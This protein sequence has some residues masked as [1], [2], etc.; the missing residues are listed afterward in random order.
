MSDLIYQT[1]ILGALFHDIG[2]FIQRGDFGNLDI[3]GRH[4]EVSATFIKSWGQF[5]AQWADL[6][7][8]ETLVTRHHES[9]VFPDSLRA[10]KAPEEIKTLC[11]LVSRADNYSSAERDT[12]TESRHF[13]TTPLTSVFS[14]IK[15]KPETQ[16]K[17]KHY[18]AGVFSPERAFPVEEDSLNPAATAALARDFGSAMEEISKTKWPSFRALYDCL[19]AILE[20]YCWCLP[21]ATQEE[22]PD[23]SLYDHL[24]TT[25]A[26]AAALY[27]Y[28]AAHNDFSIDSITDDTREKF[29]LLAGDLSGIQRYIFDIAAIGV[30]GVAKRLRAR[31]FY[32]SAVSAGLA[33]KIAYD[34]NLPSINIITMSGGNFYLLLPNTRPVHAYIERLR[35]QVN[36]DFLDRFGGELSLNLAQVPFAGKD[37]RRYNLVQRQAGEEL[38][39]AKL[40]PMADMLRHSDGSWLESAFVLE[41]TK[42]NSQ[43]Y[44]K[45]CGKLPV[46]KTMDDSA[47]CDL[48]YQD[49]A[50]GT[51]LP[52]AKMILFYHKNPQHPNSIEL[53]G[54]LW[55]LATDSASIAGNEI[56]VGYSLNIEEKKRDFT[57]IVR[58]VFGGNHVPHINGQPLDFDAIAGCSPGKK[59]LGVLKAD[60]DNLGALFSLGLGDRGTISRVATLS[61]MLDIFFSGWLNRLLIDKYPNVYLVYSGGDDLLAVGPWEQIT[62]L[63]NQVRADFVRFVGENPDITLSAGIAVVKPS[64]PIAHGAAA[65]DESLGKAKDKGPKVKGEAKDQCTLL[66]ETVKWEQLPTLIAQGRTLAG[67]LEQRLISARFVHHLLLYARMFDAYLLDRQVEGLRYIPLLSYDLN[68]NLKQ[69]EQTIEIRKWAQGLM[70]PNSPTIRHLALIARYA[71]LARRLNNA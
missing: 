6:A 25:A 13:K 30:G 21:A 3:G 71:L 20:D 9:T 43:G 37:F 46:T 58:K 57:T 14:R 28:H 26:I 2:K 69:D 54:G 33:H 36:Q 22:L 56:L 38:A 8:L 10:Q 32:L 45:S 15:L 11:L 18:R 39:L 31:S 41:K 49:L 63:I 5:L 35:I 60:I 42:S 27:E 29:L 55:L 66:G 67:W 34:L 4:P 44:C 19:A 16:V 59:M 47:V 48:C 7:L 70:D 64:F 40:S 65:A 53:P 61:R 50:L 24:R 62:N 23:I 17:Q 68:R 51:R 52:N 1:V 12:E